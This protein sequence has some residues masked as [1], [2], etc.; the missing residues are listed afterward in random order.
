MLD[1]WAGMGVLA[2]VT[3][4]KVNA[5]QFDALIVNESAAELAQMHHLDD[6]VKVS[7]ADGLHWLGNHKETYDAIVSCPPFGM[8]SQTSV[9]A[10]QGNGELKGDYAH[11]LLHES[12]KKLNP[13]ALAVFV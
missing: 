2:S 4:S 6:T 1:P 3:A 9:E 7:V 8:R 12:C 11:L 10:Y 13:G 5:E